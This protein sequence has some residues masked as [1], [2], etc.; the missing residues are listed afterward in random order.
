MPG[1]SISSLE[2]PL[3]QPIE[4]HCKQPRVHGVTIERTN[5]KIVT[6]FENILTIHTSFPCCTMTP[7]N[8]IYILQQRHGVDIESGRLCFR[9]VRST[10][11]ALPSF[12]ASTISRYVMILPPLTMV[13]FVDYLT[14]SLHFACVV[15]RARRQKA[16]RA[17]LL[18]QPYEEIHEK[19]FTRN[20]STAM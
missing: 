16:C 3:C 20:S 1:L 14:S 6:S 7:S 11:L 19:D 10:T 9:R 4:S 13:A 18:F 12:C 2:I 8:F 5:W 15:H 17:R